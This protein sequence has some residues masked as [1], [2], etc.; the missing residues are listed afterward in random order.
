VDDECCPV[1]DDGF[2]GIAVKD[3]AIAIGE[4]VMLSYANCS[5]L[6]VIK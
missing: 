3:S 4:R 6:E 2:G 1:C 5:T